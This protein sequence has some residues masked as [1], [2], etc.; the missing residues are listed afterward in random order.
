MFVQVPS[1]PAAHAEHVSET[2]TAAAASAGA[3]DGFLPHGYCYLWNKPLLLTHVTS[4]V[5]IGLWFVALGITVTT[6]AKPTNVTRTTSPG[7]ASTR[8]AF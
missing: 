4:D 1:A 6:S 2:I 5:L 8:R 7:C 3:A